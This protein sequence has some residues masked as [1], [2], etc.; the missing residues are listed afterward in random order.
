MDR[1]L[2]AARQKAQPGRDAGGLSVR[3]PSQGR[4]EGGQSIARQ[5]KMLKMGSPSMLPFLGAVLLAFALL[6]VRDGLRLLGAWE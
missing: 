4:G 2:W 5:R 6:L 1:P 3:R